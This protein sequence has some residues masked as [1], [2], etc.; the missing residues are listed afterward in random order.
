MAIR[1]L[2]YGYPDK[3]LYYALHVDNQT[4][5]CPH[6]ACPTVYKTPKATAVI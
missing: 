1:T 3:H 2:D 5:G 4:T 6:A